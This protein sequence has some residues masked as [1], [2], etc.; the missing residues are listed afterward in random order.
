MGW[1]E[2]SKPFTL[3]LLAAAFEPG[4]RYRHQNTG[5][6][7]ARFGEAVWIVDCITI[8]FP[9]SLTGW[10]G[11]DLVTQTATSPQRKP[12]LDEASFQ[13]LLSAAYVL[14]QH[15]DRLRAKGFQADF[16]ENLSA[17]VETQKLIQTLQLDLAAASELVAER[18][19]KVTNASGTA[20]GILEKG[21]LVY[22]AATGSAAIDAG[23]RIA[24]ASA[25]SGDCLSKGSALNYPDVTSSLHVRSDR[26]R[27]RDV[28]AFIAVPVYHAGQVAGVLEL[29]FARANSFREADLRTAELMAGLLSEAMVTAARMK[30]KEALASERQSMLEALERIKPQIERLGNESLLLAD[31]A[32]AKPPASSGVTKRVAETCSACGTY[33]FDENESFCGTCGA[34]RPEAPLPPDVSSL[35]V[36]GKVDPPWLIPYERENPTNGNSAVGPLTAQNVGA[37]DTAVT[38]ALAVPELRPIPPAPVAQNTAAPPT[39]MPAKP[40]STSP[41]NPSSAHFQPAVETPAT[42]ALRIF[43]ADPVAADSLSADPI[44]A[45]PLQNDLAAADPFAPTDKLQPYPWGS[46][47]K[48]HEW[49]ETVKTHRSPRAEWLAQQWQRRR[50]NIY[51]VMAGIILLLVISGW[52][53]RPAGSTAAGNAAPAQN[54]PQQKAPPQPQ[55]TLFEKLMV[56]LGLAEPPPAPVDM[57]NPNA[58]V[59]VDVHTALYYCSGSDLYGKTADGKFTTQRDAQQDQFE[60]SNRKAC[61]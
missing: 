44:P 3:Q 6:F 56:N 54:T 33:F 15:N 50:A 57:G 61:P 22:R 17:I 30:W 14:Q 21:E 4:S 49:L 19:Q 9:G 42:D 51:L 52:G 26:F 12:L 41:A 35:E 24:P 45:N 13:Q 31:L 11:I 39:E 7:N 28:K 48:A 46:A 27:S 25:L 1:P 58:Q 34:A 32:A 10:R 18:V 37:R 5:N 47:K 2:R 59:W 20:I 40:A 43:P 36:P 53:I 8:D 38:A 60:P 29:R 55:L 16:A 23:T